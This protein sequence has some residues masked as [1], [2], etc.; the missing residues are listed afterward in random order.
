LLGDKILGNRIGAAAR[1]FLVVLVGTVGI[2][3]AVHIHQRLIE[4]A[5]HNGNRVQHI[6]EGRPDI[7]LVG[8]KGNVGGHVENDVLALAGD[9]YA[10]AFEALAQLGLLVV[11]VEAD[12]AA[13]QRADPGAHQHRLAG[14]YIGGGTEKGARGGAEK[15]AGASADGGVRN[16][17]LAGIRIG[18][19]GGDEE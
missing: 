4:L 3:V 5:Q 15:G 14:L 1:K 16:L 13:G 10:G 8:G 17:L 2:G 6:I 9:R 12:A 19:A 18:G 7:R 11:H